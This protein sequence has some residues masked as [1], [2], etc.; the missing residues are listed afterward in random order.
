VIWTQLLELAI[1]IVGMSVSDNKFKVMV[2]N[3]PDGDTI[4]LV[5]VKGETK[6]MW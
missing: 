4:A 3:C 1:Q 5:S 6:L 2:I